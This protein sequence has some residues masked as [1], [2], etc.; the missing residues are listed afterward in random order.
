MR[1]RKSID[2]LARSLMH[3]RGLKWR[4]AIRMSD[5]AHRCGARAKHSGGFCLRWPEPG[6]ARCKHHGGRSTGART[7]AGKQR[8][9]DSARS[10]AA[11]QW[12]PG[13]VWYYRRRAPSP[14]AMQTQETTT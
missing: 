4:D 11:A 7:E 14:E 12:Q 10:Q 5:M 13:G 1:L 6:M 2:E 9:K 8:R 3:M